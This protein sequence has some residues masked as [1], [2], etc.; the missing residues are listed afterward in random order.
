MFVYLFIYQLIGIF[1]DTLHLLNKALGIKFDKNLIFLKYHNSLWINV[2]LELPL[3]KTKIKQK[4]V[5]I[6][7]EIW[8]FLCGNNCRRK[9]RRERRVVWGEEE[10]CVGWGA[11]EKKRE[12][13]E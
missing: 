2:H 7:I 10:G 6:I 11:V 9:E 4:K 3:K 1:F 12:K 13:E 8:S 5:R